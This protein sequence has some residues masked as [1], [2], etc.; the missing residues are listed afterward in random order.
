MFIRMKNNH[1]LFTAMIDT[2]SEENLIGPGI[3]EELKLTRLADR[4]IEIYGCRGKIPASKWYRVPY[5][6]AN[7][8]HGALPFLLSSDMGTGILLGAPFLKFEKVEIDYDRLQLRTPEGPIP[9]VYMTSHLKDMNDVIEVHF[10]KGAAATQEEDE[11]V[12]HDLLTEVPLTEGEKKQV[13]DLLMEFGNLWIGN[14]RGETH[15]L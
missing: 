3:V 11:K 15:I 1:K 5:E 8:V 9:V 2:G 7:G 12:I 13:Q 10:L 4:E 6:L 14:R